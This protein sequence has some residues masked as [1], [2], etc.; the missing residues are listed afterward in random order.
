M[1]ETESGVPERRTPKG[2]RRGVS[3][4]PALFT[5]GNLMMGFRAIILTLQQNYSHAAVYIGIAIIADLLDGRIARLTGT[6]SEFGGELDSLADVISFGVAPAVLLYRWGFEAS[7]PRQG[8]VVAFVFVTC[9]TLRLARFNVQ[10]H[11]VDSRYFV[12]L[13]IPAGAA[14]VAAVIYSVPTPINDFATALIV[15]VAAVSL[16]LLMVSTIRYRSFKSFDL[17]S[18]RS[19]VTLV[20]LA[21]VMVTIF[22]HSRPTLL[23]IATFYTVSGPLMQALGVFRRRNEPPPAVATH[24]AH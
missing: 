21:A 9:G 2:F 7:L 12:G 8:W 19:Y 5:L 4:L 6:T 1:T 18:R 17:R 24:E 23:L 22:T 11:V 20:L 10:K 15:L 14:Q 13:P 3:I 16:G